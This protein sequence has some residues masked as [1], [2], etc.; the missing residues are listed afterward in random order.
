MRENLPNA[1]RPLLLLADL[2]LKHLHV[3]DPPGRLGCVPLMWDG[4]LQSLRASL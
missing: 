2:I 4:A 1:I 3:C